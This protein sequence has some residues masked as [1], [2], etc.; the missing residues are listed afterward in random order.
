MWRAPAVLVL[1]EC[2]PLPVSQGLQVAALLASGEVNA[3]PGAGHLPWYEQPGCVAAAL[4]TVRAR[5]TDP[6]GAIRAAGAS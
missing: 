2:S 5:A 3:I 4:V 6:D 1:G